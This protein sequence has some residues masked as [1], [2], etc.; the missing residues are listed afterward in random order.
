M[1]LKKIRIRLW[2]SN[3]N[4]LTFFQWKSRML[5]V[6]R[7]CRRFIGHLYE[8]AYSPINFNLALRAT[9]ETMWLRK[10]TRRAPHVHNTQ[11][12]PR[13][14]NSTRTDGVYIFSPPA[15]GLITSIYTQTHTHIY[16]HVNN[17]NN[18]MNFILDTTDANDVYRDN[19]GRV[20]IDVKLCTVLPRKFVTRVMLLP[21]LYNN[22]IVIIIIFDLNTVA[23]LYCVARKKYITQRPL[24]RAHTR[25]GGVAGSAE[26]WIIQI[27]PSY[28]FSPRRTMNRLAGWWWWERGFTRPGILWGNIRRVYKKKN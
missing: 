10:T 20:I 12:G 28:Y 4:M 13:P 24:V 11:S 23:I 9:V 5:F 2:L 7:R 1:Y 21:Y 22:N 6:K 18:N 25:P 17:N 3:L 15:V 27:P 8:R 19:T 26:K 16:T 14:S